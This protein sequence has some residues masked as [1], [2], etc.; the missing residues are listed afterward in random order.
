MWIR[1]M[2][3]VFFAVL[4]TVALLGSVGLGYY[5][6]KRRYVRR[7]KKWE[8]SGIE[9]SVIA[10][11]SLLLSFT[12]L[13]SNNSLKDQMKLLH[14]IADATVDLR[15]QSLFVRSDIK[16]ATTGYLINYLNI[17]SAF[18]DR[19][20][21]GDKKLISDMESVNGD[22]LSTMVRNCKMN[23]DQQQDIPKALSYFDKLNAG[24]YRIIYSY[25]ERTPLIIMA[26]III[27]SWL[28]GLLVGFLNGFH[29]SRHYLVPIIFMVLVKLCVES[30]QDLDNP[31]RGLVE[32]DYSD[33]VAQLHILP[34]SGR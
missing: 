26:L 3:S 23:I 13:S 4:Y 9:N 7:N 28:I 11:F 8:P 34:H 30:I 18:N 17:M 15:R 33:F 19:F 14:D 6:S 32:P 10:I 1:F 27:S 22:Y 2:D 5:I 24:F 16:E 20:R 12:F 25:Y 31:Y 21:A 29:Q